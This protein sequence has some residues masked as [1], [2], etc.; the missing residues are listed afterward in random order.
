MIDSPA[1]ETKS[2]RGEGMIPKNTVPAA[3][4][5]V[6]PMITGQWIPPIRPG[7]PPR[8]PGGSKVSAVASGE[9]PAIAGR[10]RCPVSGVGS[11]WYAG[12]IQTAA[13]TRR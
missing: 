9:P 11:E 5:I 10:T 3:A 4:A 13:I 2:T 12:R 6:S 8:R 1:P 7:T